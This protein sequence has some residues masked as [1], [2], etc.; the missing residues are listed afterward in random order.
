M[1]RRNFIVAFILTAFG[2]TFGSSSHAQTCRDPLLW[3]FAQNSI[4]NQPIGSGASF[5]AANFKL[6]SEGYGS[7]EN[8]IIMT[9]DAPQRTIME[10]NSGGWDGGNQESRCSSAGNALGD[11]YPKAPIP[12]DFITLNKISGGT[13][14]AATAILLPDKTT[15]IQNQPLTICSAGGAVLSK[16]VYDTVNIKTSDGIRGAQGGA[17][18]SSLG[19]A[20][21]INEMIAGGTIKHALK[22]V[23]YGVDNLYYD[24]SSSKGYRWPA[25]KH[26][27]GAEPGNCTPS[28]QYC[29]TNPNLQIGALLA[30]PA[31]VDINSL[32][33]TAESS[34]MMAKAMQDYGAYAVD[35]SAWPYVGIAVE[36]G[37]AGDGKSKFNSLG[38]FN[39][40]D[41]DK[42]FTKLQI[43]NNNGPT[44]I[45]GGGTPRVAVAPDFCGAG[46][47]PGPVVTN[48]PVPGVPTNTPPATC[49][50]KIQGDANC[51]GNIKID[52]FAIWRSEFLKT[53]TTK[54][55]DF[56]ANGTVAIADFARWRTT[57]LAGTPTTPPTGATPTTPPTSAC[58]GANGATVKV[59]PIGDSITGG[60]WQLG[61]RGPLQ[62]KLKAAG[63]KFDFVG[64]RGQV[65]PQDWVDRPAEE[66]FPGSWPGTDYDEDQA[67]AANP[68]YDTDY[69]GHGG[70]QA[71]QPRAQLGISD[72]M[73]AQMVPWDIP[74]YKPELVLLHLG[75]NDI[76]GGWTYHGGWPSATAAQNVIGVIDKVAELAPNAWIL[77]SAI[78]DGGLDSTVQQ[79]VTSRI[80]Q[81][82]KMK[83]IANMYSQISPSE[84]DGVHPTEPG[85]KKMADAWFAV[86][87]PLLCN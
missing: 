2:L 76:G 64:N 20:I 17:G 14:N 33:L 8:I 3:P 31:S 23:I 82:K 66:G 71:G 30:L 12:N 49:A 65:K 43:V 32:G 42:I 52:D 6:P 85:Y 44:A 41:L 80:A 10:M 61:Y 47:T 4:W 26:D 16:Y 22:I 83:Y 59:M 79:A 87:D 46:V 7:E 15:V 57:F 53:L 68:Q 60:T 19:G 81:G 40:S 48:T 67:A 56:D 35:N 39:R 27:D 86:I 34:K 77:V 18:M 55:A 51:D 11:N 45:G 9:P 58:L 69:E 13:P 75:T 78:D 72:H 54:L 28:N 63:L 62:D 21:R 36:Y 29:G 1:S 50:K 25:Y 24:Q 38:G 74:S 70:F 5:V 84:M 37:P 73:L